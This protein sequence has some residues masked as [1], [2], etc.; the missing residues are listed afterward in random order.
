MVYEKVV[1]LSNTD[2]STIKANVIYVNET[3]AIIGI[4][5]DRNDDNK[6]DY[7][8]LNKEQ[9]KTLYELSIGKQ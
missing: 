5:Q 4:V 3:E 7:V 9:I 1:E 2:F 8:V 6:L